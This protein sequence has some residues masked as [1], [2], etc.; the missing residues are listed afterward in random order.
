MRVKHHIEILRTL[1][2]ARTAAITTASHRRRRNAVDM[3]A[4]ATEQ[5]GDERGDLRRGDERR[6]G[7][8]A[9]AGRGVRREPDSPPLSQLCGFFLKLAQRCATAD[10][11]GSSRRRP[12]AFRG[13]SPQRGP[14]SVG[15]ED[16]AVDVGAVV[17]EQEGDGDGE[18]R[19]RSRCGD[20]GL[21]ERAEAF[22]ELESPGHDVG[23]AG[24]HGVEAQASDWTFLGDATK[25]GATDYSPRMKMRQL[26]R[27]EPPNS[28]RSAR[29]LA[30][31]G[32]LFQNPDCRRCRHQLP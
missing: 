22:L 19:G 2:D 18:L 14:T 8:A 7:V 5:E 9:S 10:D 13:R 21:H 23:G 31:A 30:L 25:P 17:A 4:G 28:Q 27:W 12:L 3:R 20:G 26:I 15:G 24:G 16:G 32:H 6:G 29:A 1:D 11:G